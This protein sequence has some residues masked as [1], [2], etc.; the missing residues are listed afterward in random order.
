MTAL[1][2]SEF[3]HFEPM[4]DPD[5]LEYLRSDPK[6]GVRSYAWAA[7]QNSPDKYKEWLQNQIVEILDSNESDTLDDAMVKIASLVWRPCFIT[8]GFDGAEKLQFNRFD[9]VCWDWCKTD[10]HDLEKFLRQEICDFLF[11]VNSDAGVILM[12]A[13]S[14]VTDL[15]KKV[16]SQITHIMPSEHWHIAM[17]FDGLVTASGTLYLKNN[18][19]VVRPSLPDDMQFRKTDISLEKLSY[20]D[21]RVQEVLIWLEQIFGDPDT[22]TAF[23]TYL[24][25]ALTTKPKKAVWYGVNNN[26]KSCMGILVRTLFGSFVYGDTINGFH[27]CRLSISN[28]GSDNIGYDIV[29]TNETPDKYPNREKFHFVG[30]WSDTPDIDKQI[31]QRDPNFAERVHTLAP[32][33]LWILTQSDMP[34][35]PA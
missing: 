9:G 33:L 35:L 2:N 6:Y 16:F 27:N 23:L 31:Y 7:R 34:M 18:Q 29:I 11:K 22:I 17:L 5:T 21:A 25:T 8:I 30:Q 20:D 32:A 15:M 1:A 14:F 12:R 3:S 28:E 26:S 13:G 4:I 24:R 10:K 19:F